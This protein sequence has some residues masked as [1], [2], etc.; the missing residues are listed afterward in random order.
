MPDLMN[1]SD[2]EDIGWDDVNDVQIPLEMI[3]EARGEE[4]QFMESRKLWSI[5]PTKECLEKTGKP[6]VSVRWVDTN[7]GRDG[8]LEIR[9][10]L[11]ARDFKGNDKGRDDLFA[12]T[13]PLEANVCY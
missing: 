13:P 1:E 10:R 4:V 12:E 11:V 6:P 5:A 2:D 7:K 9:S 3:K 8:K